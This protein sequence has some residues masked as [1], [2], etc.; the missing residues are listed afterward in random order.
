MNSD[1][2]QIRD[3]KMKATDIFEA[4]FIVILTYIGIAFFG[5]LVTILIGFALWVSWT[6]YIK[7]SAERR[8][9]TKENIGNWQCSNCGH[10]N[11]PQAKKCSKCGFEREQEKE[12]KKHETVSQI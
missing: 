12:K 2:R 3:S 10:V 5:I 11:S 8:Q 4:F 7:Q 6:F 9:K 1:K